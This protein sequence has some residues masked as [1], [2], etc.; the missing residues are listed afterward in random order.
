MPPLVSLA[1]GELAQTG[2]EVGHGLASAWLAALN[3][4]E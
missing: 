2:K 1:L 4:T 3:G